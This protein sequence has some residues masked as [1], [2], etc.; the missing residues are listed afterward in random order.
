[1]WHY[2]LHRLWRQRGKS[3]LASSGFLLAA[4][5]L[6]LLSA[7]T[8]TTLVRGN[9]II[10]QNWR[11]TYDLVVL[12]PQ[13][14]IPADPRVPSDLLAGYSGGISVQQYNQ[15][16]NLA[17]IAVAAP[18]AYVGYV[19]MP[20]PY[21]YFSDH[22]FPTGYY[23]L[24]WTLSAFNGLQH[25]VELQERD[26]IYIVSGSDSTTPARDSSATGP[27]PSDV[28]AAFG[29]QI[30]EEIDE[31]DNTPI[32]LSPNGTGTFLLAGIDPAAENQL[33]HLDKSIT[34][35]RMLTEQDTIHLDSRIPGNPFVYPG[36][37]KPI[38]TDAIPMLIHRQL[39]GQIT[40]NAT[41]TLLYHGPMTADQILTGKGRHCLLA[42]AA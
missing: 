35:G 22:S 2:V 7:T 31:V 13:A 1:M 27:Q 14:K 40:L 29:G 6:I 18:I 15:V 21:I 33:V 41:L 25:I 39:P 4:C 38:P 42:T 30:N 34:S 32:P 5:S 9:Q 26:M 24:D 19:Q 3:V 23:Q 8:Q 37:S 16:K 28:L 36:S 11:P 17:G 10:S 20:V 12:P